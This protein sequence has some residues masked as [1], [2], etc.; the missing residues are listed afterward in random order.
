MLISFFPLTWSKSMTSGGK[1]MPQSVHGLFL[2]SNSSNLILS[3]RLF[4]S[5]TAF[6]LAGSFLCGLLWYSL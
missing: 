3:L 6:L 4:W 1:T 2:A 5:T